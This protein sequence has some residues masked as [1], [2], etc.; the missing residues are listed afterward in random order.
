MESN[1]YV[2]GSPYN[3][4]PIRVNAYRER[5]TLLGI[6]IGS[7]EVIIAYN[8]AVQQIVQRSIRITHEERTKV[9][10]WRRHPTYNSFRCWPSVHE[11]E[12]FF[13]EQVFKHLKGLHENWMDSVS[14]HG[15]CVLC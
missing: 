15:V 5:L 4:I 12:A 11:V 8:K 6:R 7:P 9:V 13:L 1:G 3:N 10:S 14:L 2:P